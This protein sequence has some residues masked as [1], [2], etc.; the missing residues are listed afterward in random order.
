[1]YFL[2][3]TH[4]T[5]EFSDIIYFVVDNNPQRVSVLVFGHFGCTNLLERSRHVP[6]CSSDKTERKAILMIHASDA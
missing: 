4:L 6:G 2:P 5:Y 1:M 3:N